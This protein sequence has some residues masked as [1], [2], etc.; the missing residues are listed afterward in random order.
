MFIHIGNDH[1]IRSRN[2]V[3]I[4]DCSMIDSSS[5]MEEMITSVKEKGEIKGSDSGA[6]SI[7]IT[8]RSI[9]YSSLSVSTLTKRSSIQQMV[10]KIKNHSE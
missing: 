7:I 4:I 1:V 3:S 10:Y 9:Y 2:I 5:I 6:K 8:D